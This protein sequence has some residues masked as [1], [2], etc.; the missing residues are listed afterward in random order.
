MLTT[1]LEWGGR[2]GH[3]AN[4]PAEVVASP[5]DTV[6]IAC[7][8]PRHDVMKVFHCDAA[9]TCFFENT[10]CVSGDRGRLPARSLGYGLGGTDQ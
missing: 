4:A 3:Y 1:P 9:T 2:S 10:H 7:Q 8:G 6:S 5:A